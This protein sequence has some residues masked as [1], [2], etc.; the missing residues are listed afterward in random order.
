MCF[1][2]V[3][4]YWYKPVEMRGGSDQDIRETYQIVKPLSSGGFGSTFVVSHISDM[5]EYILKEIPYNTQDINRNAGNLIS[6]HMEIDV[7]RNVK[8]LGCRQDLLCYV[9]SFP[10]YA[11]GVMCIVTEKFPAQG[12]PAPTLESWLNSVSEITQSQCLTIIKNIVNALWFLHSKGISHNDIKPSNILINPNDNYSICVIDFG[13]GCIL[14]YTK[15][16][17]ATSSP[18]FIHPAAN[19]ILTGYGRLFN[20]NLDLYSVGVILKIMLEK[21]KVASSAEVT[22]SLTLMRDSLLLIDLNNMIIHSQSLVA[23]LE[24]LQ[25]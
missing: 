5:K 1:V 12:D 21:I 3:F 16:C 13:S 11:R 17:F 19:Q 7:L 8:Y 24:N 25:I 14:N 18:G 22:K 9:E 15:Y 10:D 20:F 6:A 2:V 4:F 23:F